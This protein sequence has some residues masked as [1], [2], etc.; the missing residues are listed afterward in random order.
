MSEPTVGVWSLDF[1]SDYI[2]YYLADTL[3]VPLILSAFT[4]MKAPVKPKQNVRPFTIKWFLHV[5][6]PV[7]ESDVH[8]N[9]KCVV[10]FSCS[11]L[12]VVVVC[13]KVTREQNQTFQLHMAFRLITNMAWKTKPLKS[14]IV[15]Y[16]NTLTVQK[17][18]S[19]L[20]NFGASGF[21]MLTCLFFPPPP[22]SSCWSVLLWLDSFL[23]D[24]SPSISCWSRETQRADCPCGASLTRHLCNRC[25]PLQVRTVWLTQ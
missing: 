17:S 12:C 8:V 3:H 24:E 21:Q 4:W 16:S 22:S 25:R 19:A 15:V 11:L 13:M 14:K 23:A 5:S 7:E 1:H 2:W 9:Q 20:M 6:Q 10:L 18:V